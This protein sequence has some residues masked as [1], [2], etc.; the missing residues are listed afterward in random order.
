MA[1]HDGGGDKRLVAYVV[2]A[3]G[4]TPDVNEL[5]TRLKAR[6][7][8]YMVPQAFVV[9]EQLPL[10]PNGKL[11][12]RGLPA[13]GASPAGHAHVG[14]RQGGGGGPARTF[15]RGVRR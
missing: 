7:P 8:D 5:R 15:C 13:P 2:P 10:T 9:L 12:R 6:L 3:A 14:P 4:A 11:D 1:R